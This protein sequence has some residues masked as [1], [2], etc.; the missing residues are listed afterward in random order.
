VTQVQSLGPTWQKERAAPIHCA[1]T[2]AQEHTR[3]NLVPGLRDRA[4]RA[5]KS[6]NLDSIPKTYVVEAENDFLQTVL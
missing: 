1:S 5:E 2:W 6:Y 3:K 4:A